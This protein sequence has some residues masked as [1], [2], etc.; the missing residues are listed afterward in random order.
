MKLYK[1]F[2]KEEYIQP[3]LDGI[4]T[5]TQLSLLIC[6]E[7]DHRI[8]PW[9]GGVIQQILPSDKMIF[10][11][12]NNFNLLTCTDKQYGIRQSIRPEKAK[13]IYIASFSTTTNDR[14][15]KDFGE[16]V[17]ECDFTNFDFGNRVTHKKV[18][19][20]DF[21]CESG[22]FMNPSNNFIEKSDL[23]KLFTKHSD[24]QWQY[25]YR[26]VMTLNPLRLQR[27]CPPLYRSISNNADD[28]KYLQM[29]FGNDK[30]EK[31]FPNVTICK[32]PNNNATKTL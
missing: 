24:Y 29:T 18:V 4:F 17:L 7:Q 8:D 11:D 13:F 9:E 21:N 14:L 15:T 5:W 27:Y 31:L 26:F 19:Y 25:E 16:Y 22:A 10:R 30:G 3:W 32:K 28:C 2:N 6:G 12:Y 20:D 1:H 23:K